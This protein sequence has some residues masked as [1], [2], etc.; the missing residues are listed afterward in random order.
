MSY[1]LRFVRDEKT[2]AVTFLVK[3]STKTRRITLSINDLAMALMAGKE[4]KCQ[5]AL[6]KDIVQKVKKIKQKKR[7]K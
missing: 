6:V 7:S 4:V 2:N 5:V 1:T 3:G